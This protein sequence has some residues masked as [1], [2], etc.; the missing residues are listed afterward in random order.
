MRNTGMRMFRFLSV[1][2]ALGFW[3]FPI[4]SLGPVTEE[5]FDWKWPQLVRMTNILA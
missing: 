3:L 4:E 5:S 1:K 2:P